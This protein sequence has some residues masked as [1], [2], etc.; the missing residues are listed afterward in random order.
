MKQ[1]PLFHH[2]SILTQ[3][4]SWTQKLLKFCGHVPDKMPWVKSTIFTGYH[5]R[6]IAG[7]KILDL[8]SVA[9]QNKK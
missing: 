5:I 2:I 9:E 1:Y 7:S 3:F 6:D 8:G 4:D